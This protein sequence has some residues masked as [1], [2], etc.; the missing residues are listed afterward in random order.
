MKSF[1]SLIKNGKRAFGLAVEFAPGLTLALFLITVISHLIPLLQAKILGDIVNKIIDAVGTGASIGIL[2]LITAY[3]AIWGGSRVMN[4]FELYTNKLWRIRNEYGTT[5]LFLKKRSE[6]DLAHYENPKFQDLLQRVSN[7]DIWPMIEMTDVQFNIF[8]NIAVIAASSFIASLIDWKL[9]L[10]VIAAAVPSF[11]VQFKYGHKVWSIWAEHSERKR[12]Y[13]SLRGHLLGRTGVTQAKLLQN[14]SKILEIIS[15]LLLSFQRDIWKADRERLTWQIMASVITAGGLGLAFWMIVGNATAGIITVGTM[16]FVIN[17][18]GQLIGSLNQLMSNIANQLEKN[19]YV[20]DMFAL[21]DTR[22]FIKRANKPVKLGLVQAPAIE[23]KDVSFKYEGQNDL[24]LKKINLTINPGEK[25]ALV[26]MNGAGKTTLVKLLG[27]IYDPT[28]GDIYI[29]DINLKDADPE[30]WSR[31]LSILL[32]DYRNYEL[33]VKES[34]GMGRT[35]RLLDI[36]KIR[37]ASEYTGANEFI[38]R[39]ENQYDQ[40]LGKEFEGGVEPSHGQNQKITLART[41]YRDG[42]VMILDEPTASIDALSEMKIFEQ[43]EKAAKDRTLI[44]I[45]HRFNTTKNF[46]RII[47][48]EKGE[49]IENGPHKELMDLNGKYAEMFE[50]QAKAFRH[51]KSARQLR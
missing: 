46:D 30:E 9:Y 11:F 5:I 10:L 6:I 13:A 1:F 50:S 25:I 45:T 31:Y 42:L 23:L 2:A 24:V 15:D 43:M 12:L 33:K 22:P 41:I 36:E 20:T 28:K 40:R 49:V 8:A 34:I 35:D 37:Q 48:L 21:L 32:Q 4:A 17:A 16:V 44:V 14:G 3:A 47:V 29:N 7:R 19:L 39:W 38:E 18:L 26:G 51:E 27:R